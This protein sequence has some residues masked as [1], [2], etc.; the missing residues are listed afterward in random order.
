MTGLN[1][2]ERRWTAIKD[3]SKLPDAELVRKTADGDDDAFAEI[4][5][6]YKNY[7]FSVIRQSVRSY[8]DAEDIA[9]ESFIDAWR[10]ISALR[11]P[12]KLKFWLYGIARRKSL[13]YM[14][15]RRE[16][17]NVDDYEIADVTLTEDYTLRKEKLGRVREA[18][19]KLSEKNRTVCV[20]FYAGGMSVE[21]I[22]VRLGL[23]QG[24]VKSRLFEARNQLREELKEMDENN[25]LP[26]DFD[27]KIKEKIKE[28][29]YYY[30]F[31][32]ESWDGFDEAF[33]EAEKLINAVPDPKAR[34]SALSAIYLQKAY[35]KDNDANL[36]AKAKETALSG[37]NGEVLTSLFVDEAFAQN[38]SEGWL[39]V[40]DNRAIPE[41][42]RIGYVS[43]EGVMRFWR[44]RALLELKRYAEAYAEFKKAAD[45]IDRSDNY[46]A[47]ALTAIRSV[48]LA[49]EYADDPNAEI[50]AM[51][52]TYMRDS[53]RVIM[54][55]EPGFGGTEMYQ[56][57]PLDALGYYCSRYN[58]AFFDTSVAAG[59]TRKT[60]D[61]DGEFTVISYDE[62]V[63]VPAGEFPHAM[64][65]RYE[66]DN[67]T[68]NVWYAENV[69]LVKADFTG[70]WSYK[71]GETYE[72]SE[73]EI[74]G[75]DGYYPFALGNRWRYVNTGLPEY[76]FYRHE[77]E[78][79]WI[80]D[81]GNTVNVSYLL[82]A[83]FMKNYETEY[84]LESYAYMDK[85]D[86]LSDGWNLREA[87]EAL[88][89]A[90]QANSTQEDAALALSWIPVMERFAD[91]HEKGW[92]FCPG[93]MSDWTLKTEKNGV[94]IAYGDWSLGPYRL[95]TRG[96][97]ED[98]IFGVKPLRYLEQLAGGAW[99]DEWKPGYTGT[100]RFM[101]IDVTLAVTDGGTVTVPAGTFDNCVKL[102][103]TAEKTDARDPEYYFRDNY[104][105]MFC[106][107]KEF[108][109]APGVG[110]V[111]HDCRWG[112]TDSSC[113]LVKYDLPAADGSMFPVQIGNKWEYDEVHLTEEN[114]RA[115][116]LMSIICGMGDKFTVSVS[117]EF[118]WQGTEEEYENWKK[119]HDKVG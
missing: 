66:E 3:Y 71:G 101:D 19:M 87:A 74:K 115:K 64:H 95:G 16:H 86:R 103:I 37:G 5:A 56:R 55:S 75:G 78:V 31:H 60:K 36:A 110:I 23:P 119:E 117:Q 39:D 1:K 69:G 41:L 89:K 68:V 84:Q 33:S 27:K 43:G 92:R 26:K 21:Q 8:A 116:F 42:Q 62:P 6:R 111:K 80:S 83:F 48:D 79:D 13:K 45:M 53:S 32:G 113:V 12:D 96:H 85:A 97:K 76:L 94:R 46:H 44:G 67:F 104:H 99:N 40:I 93:S 112:D 102:T 10:G 105:Y 18:V 30:S 100:R 72:L 70:E 47:C 20:M 81:D 73:Y 82:A 49:R 51:S 106:G 65:V 2:N 63:S 88:K 11:E 14:S 118:I 58:R 9:Q 109:Y 59:E 61:G 4:V 77:V 108:W 98:R 24:T 34:D 29:R 52:E 7:V 107:T 25:T 15:R 50:H 114:Y 35:S 22:A 90:V 54:T 38:E 91:Y 17:E 28:I 57:H